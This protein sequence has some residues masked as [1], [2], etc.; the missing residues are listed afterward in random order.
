MA[1]GYQIMTGE[2]FK[3]ASGK[4]L[5]P[6]EDL[7]VYEAVLAMVGINPLELSLAQEKNAQVVRIDTR[8]A[9]RKRQL[10][11]RFSEAVRADNPDAID[12]AIADVTNFNTSMPE[13]AFKG[14]EL[15]SAV[16]EGVKKELGVEGNRQMLIEQRYGL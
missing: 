7:S 9:D 11:R 14:S 15:A 8:I 12:S 16:K 2:G 5:V 3:S 1:K 4:L 13:F 10:S 6:A